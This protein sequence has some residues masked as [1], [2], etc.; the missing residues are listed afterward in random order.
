MLTLALI[1]QRL[2]IGAVDY[3]LAIVALVAIDPGARNTMLE[4]ITRKRTPPALAEH[5]LVFRRCVGCD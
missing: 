5:W 3:L 2:A 4:G 1:G